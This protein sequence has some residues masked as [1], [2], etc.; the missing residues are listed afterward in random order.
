V[1]YRP[2][3]VHLLEPLV[4]EPQESLVVDALRERVLDLVD[5]R[6]RLGKALPA[7]L[8]RQL[9]SSGGGAPGLGKVEDCLR[10]LRRLSDPGQMADLVALMLLGEPLAR[11]IILQS[12][13]IEERLRHLE[14]LLRFEL[15]QHQAGGGEA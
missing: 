2:Y 15:E 5:A 8:L 11:Q 10:A 13:G 3:R 4:T 14:R 7:E 1:K 6:L 9:A 12:L